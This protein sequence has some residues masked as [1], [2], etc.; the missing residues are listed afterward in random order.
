MRN[1]IRSLAVASL[2]LAVAENADAQMNAEAMVR[3]TLRTAFGELDVARRYRILRGTLL[4]EN[5]MDITTAH[6]VPREQ[7][8]TAVYQATFRNVSGP[9]VC[10]RFK[11]IYED[12]AY[13]DP[14]FV[15]STSANH[16]VTRRR[17]VSL[18]TVYGTLEG[19]NF[20]T[21]RWRLGYWF[22]EPAESGGRRCDAT[23]PADLDA[24]IASRY[25]TYPAFKASR[26]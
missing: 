22:W 1:S 13:H 25:D 23:A 18:L 9:A 3:E 14:Q 12:D 2:L 21:P 8:A 16:L 7:L 4:E 20:N 17:H 10:A 15:Q 11:V 5:G 26:P 6:A 19:V 24:W